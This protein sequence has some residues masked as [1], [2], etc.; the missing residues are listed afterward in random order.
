MMDPV[1]VMLLQWSLYGVILLFIL[2]VIASNCFSVD[3]QTVRM[4]T[5]FG[6]YARTATAGLNVKLPFI[7]AKSRP[8]SLRTEQHIVKVESITKD[9]VTVTLEISV[10]SRVI[11]ANAYE[12]FYKLADPAKQIESYV[13]DA[14]RS[15]VPEMEL[16]E[17][18]QNKGEIAGAVETELKQDMA[19]YGFEIQRALVTEI[20]PN[21]KVV[22]AM[23]D[24]NAAQREQIAATA[25]GEANKTLVIKQAEAEA[26]QKKLRREGVAAEREAIATGIRNSLQTIKD[27]GVPIDE[28]L[29]I[30]M[31]AQGFD[32]MRD[33]AATGKSTIIFAPNAPD[34]FAKMF[35]ALAGAEVASTTA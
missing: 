23:N 35:T 30:L 25:R 14:V 26:A 17:V 12:A 1:S 10:Q 19:E 5:R 28:V 29:R 34:G 18:F 24:I 27:A 3:Q 2:A 13:F 11:P 7:E 21:Q 33:M 8:L 15:K 4:I 6:K 9:K 31:T 16:D 32:A 20:T 22:D